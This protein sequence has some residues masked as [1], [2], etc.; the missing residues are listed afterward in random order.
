LAMF[1]QPTDLRLLQH[2]ERQMNMSM[3]YHNGLEP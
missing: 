1:L 3:L 2:I